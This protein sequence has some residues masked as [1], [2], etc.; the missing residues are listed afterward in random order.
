MTATPGT[1]DP[2]TLQDQ[3]VRDGY[4]LLRGVL[5]PAKVL[6]ARRR[7]MEQLSS[8]G[9]LQEG[10]DIMDA[11]PRS[12]VSLFFQ[13][14]LAQK[15]NPELQELLY[16]EDGELMQ[17]FSR[18]LGGKVRHYDFTWL[19]CMTP[20]PGTPAHCDIVYMG[21][22]THRLFTAWVPLGRAD[23]KSGGLMVLEGSHK[24]VDLQN[25]YGKKDVDSFCA[26]NPND[27][28]RT[29]N[30]YNGWLPGN[31]NEIREQHGKR[32]LVSEFEPGDAVIFCMD[33]VHGGLDNVSSSL[34]LSSDSRYQ[35][36]T[37]PVD[38]RWVGENPPGHS[39]AGKK[40]RIC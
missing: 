17:W 13:P 37:D 32:W 3:M 19:R 10:V 9:Q 21:R 36:A 6:A 29:A 5:D 1:T 12:G 20:G 27:E 30:G 16:A 7:V 35:L 26:N 31:C 25:T 40:G 2:S 33:L 18:F 28:A 8:E 15:N 38:E 22:G 4:I 34:R 24:D 11:V 14:E 23:F 39:A